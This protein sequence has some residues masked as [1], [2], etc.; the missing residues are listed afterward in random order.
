MKVE[1]FDKAK[2]FQK[3]DFYKSGKDVI[4]MSA[5]C[6]LKMEKKDGTLEGNSKHSCK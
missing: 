1:F 4:L 6:P 3:V 5:F 2:F